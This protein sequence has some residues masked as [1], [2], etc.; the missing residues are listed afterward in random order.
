MD[1]L[2]NTVET[3]S[4]IVDLQKL[5]IDELFRKICEYVTMEEL[6]QMP[7]I[8]KINE[9]AKLREGLEGGIK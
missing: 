5:A 7:C 6:D 8:A 3:Y 1:E 9:A 2:M 4:L